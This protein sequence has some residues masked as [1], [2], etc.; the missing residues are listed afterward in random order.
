MKRVL[1]TYASRCG[2]TAE[3][4]RAIGMELYA[5]G[6][7]VDVQH[8]EDVQDVKEYDAVVI[9]SA[10]RMG[11]WLPAAV[12]FVEKYADALRQMPTAC[13]TVHLNAVDDSEASRAQRASYLDAVR[14]VFTPQ[15]EAF[16]AG[17]LDFSTLN[18]ID[19]FISRMVKAPEI[20]LRDWP[21][22]RGWADQLFED[23]LTVKDSVEP[24]TATV[25]S[26]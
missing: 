19:R 15:E 4:A 1:V 18:W 26:S 3:V 20:D 24:S 12:A 2:S 23:E 13:F 16:F 25:A 8:V 7:C 10:V 11:K 6:L 5:R 9:G 21:A 17:K 14:K 22:I